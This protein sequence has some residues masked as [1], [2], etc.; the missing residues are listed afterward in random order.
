MAALVAE[1]EIVWEIDKWERFRIIYPDQQA[2]HR[3]QATGPVF[4]KMQV[5]THH[6]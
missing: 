3:M 5:G 1:A 4:H 6:L 2:S